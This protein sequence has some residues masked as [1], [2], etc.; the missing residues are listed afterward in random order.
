MCHVQRNAYCQDFRG[1]FL[2]KSTLRTLIS[3]RNSFSTV[4]HITKLANIV[5]M[6]LCDTESGFIYSDK[7]TLR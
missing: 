2:N 7:S 1:R 4:C 5:E 6:K 3:Y